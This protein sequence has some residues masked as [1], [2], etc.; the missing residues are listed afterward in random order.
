[1]SNVEKLYELLLPGLLIGLIGLLVEFGIGYKKKDHPS[2]KQGKS[3]DARH[4]FSE[5]H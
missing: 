5:V 3:K 2:E 4:D 1:M